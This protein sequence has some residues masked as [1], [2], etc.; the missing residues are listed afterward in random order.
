MLQLLN[1]GV[2]AGGARTNGQS[3]IDSCSAHD[4]TGF[5]LRIRIIFACAPEAFSY[6]ALVH[7]IRQ[8]VRSNLRA[9]RA[10]SSILPDGL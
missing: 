1:N 2:G 5:L 10:C 6:R 3:V 4:R 7:Y 8:N 9:A